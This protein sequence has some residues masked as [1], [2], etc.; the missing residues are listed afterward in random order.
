MK[1]ILATLSLFL[2]TN[3]SLANSF[4]LLIISGG[5]KPVYNPVWDYCWLTIIVVFLAVFFISMIN[6]IKNNL[7]IPKTDNIEEKKKIKRVMLLYLFFPLIV[8]TIGN[9]VLYVLYV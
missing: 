5:K 3:V 1:K 6:I 9:I 2:L 7:Y 4:D 8:I